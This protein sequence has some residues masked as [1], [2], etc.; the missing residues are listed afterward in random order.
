[1]YGAIN[2]CTPLPERIAEARSAIEAEQKPCDPGPWEAWATVG[3][4]S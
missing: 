4:E 2:F 1:M 3:D